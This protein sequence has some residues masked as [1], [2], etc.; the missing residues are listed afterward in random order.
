MNNILSYFLCTILLIIYFSILSMP[1]NGAKSNFSAAIMVSS[2]IGFNLA[3]FFVLGLTK[4]KLKYYILLLPMI[5]VQIIRGKLIPFEY[6]STYRRGRAHK[7]IFQKYLYKLSDISS[8][9]FIYLL[10]LTGWKPICGYI[11][12]K[13]K[14]ILMNPSVLLGPLIVIAAA[15]HVIANFSTRESIKNKEN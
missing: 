1:F 13:F 9:I 14:S 12:S 6:I 15:I 8:L 10:I 11:K 3:V 2:I 7:S 5:L 4:L